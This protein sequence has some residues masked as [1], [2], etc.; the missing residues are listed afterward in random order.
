MLDI[1]HKQEHLL[2][3]QVAEQLQLGFSAIFAMKN[4]IYWIG[5]DGDN[6][7]RWIYRRKWNE[8]KPICKFIL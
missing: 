1:I 2:F 4:E 7:T 6:E 8:Y 3:F 5:D